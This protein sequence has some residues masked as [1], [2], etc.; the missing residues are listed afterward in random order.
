V[1]ANTGRAYHILKRTLSDHLFYFP[2]GQEGAKRAE[3]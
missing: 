2:W 1:K 3:S